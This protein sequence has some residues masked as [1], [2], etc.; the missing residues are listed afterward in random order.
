MLFECCAEARGDKI[1]RPSP[2]AQGGEEEPDNPGAQTGG[3]CFDAICGTDRLFA[4][5]KHDEIDDDDSDEEDDYGGNAPDKRKDSTSW[6]NA[7]SLL[8]KGASWL[9]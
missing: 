6:A 1:N 7:G 5:N 3:C 4:E 2:P 9:E 8:A